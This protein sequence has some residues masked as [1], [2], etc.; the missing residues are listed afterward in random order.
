MIVDSKIECP[1]KI[2]VVDDL[3]LNVKFLQEALSVMGYGVDVAYD[4]LQALEKVAEDAPDLILLDVKMPRMDGLTVCQRLKS[5]EKT[6]SIPVVMVTALDELEINVKALQCG[7]NY[8]IVKPL[9]WD[10]LSARIKSL[11]LVKRLND[12]IQRHTKTIEKQYQKMNAE[13]RMAREVQLAILPHDVPTVPGVRIASKYI[14]CDYVSGDLYDFVGLPDGTLWLIIADVSGHGVP[15]ALISTL[16]KALLRSYISEDTSPENVA[17]SINDEFVS[18]LDRMFVTG[19]L[20]HFDPK[21]R[22]FQYISAGHPPI[23]LAREGKDSLKK[24][25]V[26]SSPIGI[27]PGMTFHAETIQL[28]DGDKLLFYTDGLLECRDSA[29]ERFGLP[30]LKLLYSQNSHLMPHELLTLIHEQIKSF[31]GHDKF[32]DDIAIFILEVVG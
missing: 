22:S 15:A 19:I 30:H 6:R 9:E 3:P 10:I 31:V 13:L 11:L 2:L 23:L 21:N 7:A 4:G 24:L 20:G 17:S 26:T 27:L 18:Y 14:P 5:D 32:D 25:A 29:R 28:N 1:A 8:F 16:T 12:D